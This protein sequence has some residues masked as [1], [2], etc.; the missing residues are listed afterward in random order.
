[1]VLELVNPLSKKKK[2]KKKEWV[3]N[4]ITTE[5]ADVALYSTETNDDEC[6]DI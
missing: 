4:W 2:K 1:M 6:N 5:I 3:G